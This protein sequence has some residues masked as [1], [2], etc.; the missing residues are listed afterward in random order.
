MNRI[1]I[2]PELWTFIYTH[3]CEIPRIPTKR[4]LQRQG[5]PTK[6]MPLKN[7][8]NQAV[9][10]KPPSHIIRICCSFAFTVCIQPLSALTLFVCGEIRVT[11]QCCWKKMVA[12]PKFY[13]IHKPIEN[14]M[15]ANDWITAL[16]PRRIFCAAFY[17]HLVCCWLHHGYETKA[18]NTIKFFMISLHQ[19]AYL[20]GTIEMVL[21][22]EWEVPDEGWMFF[23][24]SEVEFYICTLCT[25][26]EYEAKK[27]AQKQNQHKTI[28]PSAVPFY[29]DKFYIEFFFLSAKLTVLLYNFNFI[30]DSIPSCII[31]NCIWLSTWN[32][33]IDESHHEVILCVPQFGCVCTWTAQ[34]MFM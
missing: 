18:K 11:I 10:N 6:K 1:R 34:I 24:S 21:F 30:L 14:V 17:Y 27:Y 8:Q 26:E 13:V 23:I 7:E 3:P 12:T 16:L 4:D 2:Q 22:D 15:Y 28:K 25:V 29:D 19:F 5:T 33:V 32:I 31:W 20:C 9:V